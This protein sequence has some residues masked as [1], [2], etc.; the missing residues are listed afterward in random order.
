MHV[1]ELPG[2]RQKPMTTTVSDLRVW[3]GQIRSLYSIQEGF[4]LTSNRC[5][6]PKKQRGNPNQMSTSSVVDPCD[7]FLF[8]FVVIICGWF[9]YESLAYLQAFQSIRFITLR[10][11][12]DFLWD[13]EFWYAVP[14]QSIGKISL[15]GS[16]T[17]RWTLAM[18][19]TKG[20]GR[21]DSQP[22][23]KRR[24]HD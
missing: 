16:R 14:S 10:E 1:K 9:V 12:E 8:A 4:A 11:E 7:S 22:Q 21:D 13:L 20:T 19:K 17:W 24:M 23:L 18:R 15:Q 5:D 6:F 2:R 3:Q